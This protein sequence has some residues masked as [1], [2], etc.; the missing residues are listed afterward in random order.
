MPDHI[1][2]PALDAAREA[3]G[4]DAPKF[5]MIE[6]PTIADI[7]CLALD[8]ALGFAKRIA[9]VSALCGVRQDLL[10]RRAALALL[11]AVS[12]DLLKQGN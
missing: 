3:L 7:E 8:L 6:N 5:Q 12:P 10:A 11:A 9:A 2:T 4:I 1:E